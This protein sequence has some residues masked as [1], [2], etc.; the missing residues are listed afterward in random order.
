MVVDD[1]WYQQAASC[2]DDLCAG[3]ADV[4][5]AFNVFDDSSA[6]EQRCLV[7]FAL[8]QDRGMSDNSLH[9]RGLIFDILRR[10]TPKSA[11]L[12]MPPL[13][14]LVPSSRF[15]KITGT[16]LTLKPRHSALYFISIWKA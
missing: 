2:V 10:M 12:N 6:D 16:S 1:A 7:A 8:V 15:T 9:L 14:L 4:A 11:S 5:L 3:Q 13:I